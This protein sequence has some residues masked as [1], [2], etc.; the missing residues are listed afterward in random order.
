[1]QKSPELEEKEKGTRLRTDDLFII[2][3]ND[4]A[5]CLETFAPNKKLKCA[6]DGLTA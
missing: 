4:K 3:Q 2:F 5:I 6:T 1:M